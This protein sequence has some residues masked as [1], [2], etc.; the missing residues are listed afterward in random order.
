MNLQKTVLALVLGA[1]LA[2]AARADELAYYDLKGDPAAQ[3]ATWVDAEG[4]EK[5]AGLRRVVIPQFRIEFQLR[6]EASASDGRYL[7]GGQHASASNSA[8][9][10]LK[11]IDDP[12]LV[13]LR[14]DSGAIVEVVCASTDLPQALGPTAVS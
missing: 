14:L 12:A 10:H 13:A 11:G 7:G 3:A 8:Y 1:A 4:V 5:L 9:V 2:G 6:A